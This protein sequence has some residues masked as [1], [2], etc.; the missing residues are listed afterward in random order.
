MHPRYERPNFN[1]HVTPSDG[2]GVSS[3]FAFVF[4]V[5]ITSLRWGQ[6]GLYSLLALTGATHFMGPGRA[7]P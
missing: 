6:G 4:F 5:V 1:V 7:W 2:T 3:A